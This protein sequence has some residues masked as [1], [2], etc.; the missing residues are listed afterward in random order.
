MWKEK[1]YRRSSWQTSA[2]YQYGKRN[3]KDEEPGRG[4]RG[5]CQSK[6]RRNI[7]EAAR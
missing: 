5:Q 7:R 3:R 2:P 6:R 1:D 4:V